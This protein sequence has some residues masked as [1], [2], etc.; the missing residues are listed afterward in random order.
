[1][2]L[3]NKNCILHAVN[4][5]HVLINDMKVLQREIVRFICFAEQLNYNNPVVVYSCVKIIQRP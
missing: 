2:S 5:I 1:M 4:L 3:E